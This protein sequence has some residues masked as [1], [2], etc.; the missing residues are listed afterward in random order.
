VIVLSTSC[1]SKSNKGNI[2]LSC[3][4]N[5]SSQFKGE[6]NGNTRELLLLLWQGGT[7]RTRESGKFQVYV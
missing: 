2:T 5:M 1:G 6:L 7:S 3:W 4:M